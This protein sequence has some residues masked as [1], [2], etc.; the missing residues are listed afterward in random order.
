MNFLLDS[1]VV[2]WCL[3]GSDRLKASVRQLLAETHGGL[4]VSAATVWELG[5]KQS[6][7]K[8]RMPPH[9]PEAL[10]QAGFLELPIHHRHA[11]AAA[12]LPW[13]HKDPFDRLLVAQAQLEGL[14]L[15]SADAWV[16]A[17]GVPWLQA[18][19]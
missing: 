16:P 9:L 15:V 12:A 3:E 13:H 18:S 14:T 17:Y 4:F 10:A 19:T 7:V 1:H 5:I 8:L 11:E 6:L 2:L